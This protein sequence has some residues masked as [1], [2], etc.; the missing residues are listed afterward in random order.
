MRQ[1]FIDWNYSEWESDKF[2]DAEKEIEAHYAS[3]S[4]K[5]RDDVKNML[6]DGE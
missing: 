5:I 6:K 3:A 2:K 1:K 4:G